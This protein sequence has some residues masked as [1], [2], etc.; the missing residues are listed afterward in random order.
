VA[1]K[2]LDSARTEA[3]AVSEMV[4]KKKSMSEAAESALQNMTKKATDMVKLGKE[5]K[6]GEHAEEK[7]A[8]HSDEKKADAIPAKVQNATVA[9]SADVDSKLAALKT[10]NE[11]LKLEKERL[12]KQLQAQDLERQNEKLAKEKEELEKKVQGKSAESDRKNRSDGSAAP[13][14]RGFGAAPAPSAAPPA[15]LQLHKSLKKHVH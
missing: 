1:E 5:K 12:A 11:R 9:L 3:E 4:D 6:Q 10:E 13:A 15:K 7:Q 8:E 14:A 2:T